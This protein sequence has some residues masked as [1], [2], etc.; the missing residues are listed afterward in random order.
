MKFEKHHSRFADLTLI[1]NEI[2]SSISTALQKYFNHKNSAVLSDL[3]NLAYMA[4]LHDVIGMPLEFLD[5][6]YINAV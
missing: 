3:N 2:L 4:I 6:S 1:W 5:S